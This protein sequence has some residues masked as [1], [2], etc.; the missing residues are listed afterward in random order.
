MS[1]SHPDSTRGYAAQ[2]GLR[3]PLRGGPDSLLERRW[4]VVAVPY[5]LLMEPSG[6]VAAVWR[7]AMSD[8]DR[9]TAVARIRRWVP[10]E[11]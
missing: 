4:K 11:R 1:L 3:I 7:G 2:T 6:R 8:T 5:T 9:D 10:A